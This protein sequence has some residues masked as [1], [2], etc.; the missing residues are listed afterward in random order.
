MS[1]TVT[2]KPQPGVNVRKP[3]GQHL[4]EAG[5]AVVMD[6]FWK[7]RLKDGDVSLVG[8]SPVKPATGAAGGKPK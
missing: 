6:G 5:E 7:R 1:D 2:L 8:N 4:A 3:N